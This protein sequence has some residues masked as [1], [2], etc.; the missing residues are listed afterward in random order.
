MFAGRIGDQRE[1][2]N[3]LCLIS[4]VRSVTKAT[5]GITIALLL[6]TLEIALRRDKDTFEPYLP[7]YSAISS[8]GVIS[9]ERKDSDRHFG[10]IKYLNPRETVNRV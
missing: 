3:S 5:V 7:W 2:F 6:F 10:A 4:F 9:S 1:T 8:L